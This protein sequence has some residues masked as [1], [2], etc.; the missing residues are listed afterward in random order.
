[1]KS[2]CITKPTPDRL[3]FEAHFGRRV[4]GAFD[5]G[6]ISSDGGA[7]LLREVEQRFGLIR[8]FATCF[9]DSRNPDL[10]EFPL[11]TL[12][13]QRVFGLAL[14][15]ED[16]NDH[17]ALRHDPLLALA[18]GRQDLCGERRREERD[19][20]V[21]LAGKSTLNR[22]EDSGGK[23]ARQSRRYHR[24]AAHPEQIDALLLNLFVESFETPPAE[25]VLDL[26]ATDDPLHGAQEGR[27][28]HG[29]Y[30][31]YC[32]LPLYIFCGEQLL[33]ARLRTSDRDGADGAQEE[34][35]R[36]VA[37][38]RQAWPGVRILLRG[39]SGFCRENL[40]AWCEA[41]GVDYLFGLAQNARLK[42]VLATLMRWARGRFQFTGQA[43]RL[44]HEFTYRTKDSW[45]RA[46]R[47]VGKAEYLDGGENPRFVVTSLP[48]SAWPAQQLYEE[49]YCARGEMEN[50]IKEQQLM[51]FAD[52]TSTQRLKS[53][54]L[55]LYLSSL[56][57]VLLQTLRRVA[58]SGT[59]WA[60]AQCATIRE[61][62]LKVGVRLSV[63]VR[64]VRL[65]Y[66]EC[67][68]Y[69]AQFRQVLMRLQKI[70]LRG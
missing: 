33:C 49:L 6:A 8:R 60:R 70:P 42:Q 18:C 43:Q 34:V 16:L 3:D 51:L 39:D 55:R 15:Y 41:S 26:D 12:L 46:R 50:R 37:H 5:G 59:D 40:M 21:P 52:R 2:Q 7:L 1:M 24:I 64:R 38:L 11:E 68:P 36:I 31:A 65:S 45:G 19:R 61:K 4:E 62:L 20:G 47:V 56:A 9:T 28:F 35:E 67:Y 17:D 57:Y 27:F 48:R 10:I 44:F 30:D 23:A 69:A 58:L 14:G 32:Y 63:S 13:A 29:Y 53:N 25:L 22:L 66:S 54:Q